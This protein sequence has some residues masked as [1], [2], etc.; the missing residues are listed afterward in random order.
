MY[1]IYTLQYMNNA[2]LLVLSTFIVRNLYSS[3][4]FQVKIW[5]L[6]DSMILCAV[7]CFSC[8]KKYQSKCKK[9]P[10]TYECHIWKMSVSPM[11]ILIRMSNKACRLWKISCG[12]MCEKSKKLK[13][14]KENNHLHMNVCNSH[15]KR[16][17]RHMWRC[18]FIC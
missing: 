4:Q 13:D 9:K 7:F 15:T 5:N 6:H 16:R 8:E 14:K 11:D 2:L 10:V 1:S 3:S 17:R 18:S 12:F